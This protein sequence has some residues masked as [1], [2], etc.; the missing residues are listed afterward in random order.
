M[1][2]MVMMPREKERPAAVVAGP[3]RR[4]IYDGGDG[5][6][7]DD[8]DGNSNA[9]RDTSGIL[10]HRR[11]RIGAV[12]VAPTKATTQAQGARGGATRFS[13]SR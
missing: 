5:V 7:G 2:V 1:M 8:D 9:S 12:A 13:S 3:W 6:G 10:W 4:K 11:N